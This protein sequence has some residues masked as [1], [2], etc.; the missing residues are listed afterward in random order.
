MEMAGRPALTLEEI[1]ACGAADLGDREAGFCLERALRPKLALEDIIKCGRLVGI[2]EAA[3][4][5]KAQER[6]LLSAE[7]K[8]ACEEHFEEEDSCLSAAGLFNPGLEK[9]RACGAFYDGAGETLC[10]KKAAAPSLTAEEIQGCGAADFSAGSE[11]LCLEKAQELSFDSEALA[12]CGA[13]YSENEI[14]CLETISLAKNPEAK[15]GAKACAAYRGANEMACLA[16]ALKL[17]RG[18]SPAAPLAE[19][20]AC[21]SLSFGAESERFCLDE[22]RRRPLSLTKAQACAGAAASSQ[23]ACLRESANPGL[24]AEKIRACSGFP[25]EHQEACFDLAGGSA[26]IFPEKI[27]NCQKTGS[28]LFCLREAENPRLSSYKILLCSF[29]PSDSEPADLER[30]CLMEASRLSPKT[31]TL[32]QKLFGGDL[33]P[34]CLKSGAEASLKKIKACGEINIADKKTCLE[35]IPEAD[36]SVRKIQL[37][38]SLSGGDLEALCLKNA[39]RFELDEDL[40]ACLE[41]KTEDEQKYCLQSQTWL[42]EILQN[43]PSLNIPESLGYDQKKPEGEKT[44]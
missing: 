8:E 27:Q 12:I 14:P 43:L 15:A 3:C 2:D 36:I 29:L 1:R 13:F 28:A 16:L 17:G 39:H 23:S 35:S 30:I 11:A 6:F 38:A 26:E 37:C 9:L 21:G 25:P 32:C 20:R 24:S 34:L 19:L 44:R 18:G 31:I 42:P 7:E 4:L 40:T 33:L 22:A 41:A 10:L 5:R